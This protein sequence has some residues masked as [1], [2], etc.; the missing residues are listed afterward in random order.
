[1]KFLGLP[2]V[3]QGEVGSANT[4][5]VMARAGLGFMAFDPVPSVAER[6]ARGL[7]GLP[8]VDFARLSRY[9]PA[10]VEAAGL[11]AEAAGAVSRQAVT[12]RKGQTPAQARVA[13][14]V[15]SAGAAGAIE[16]VQEHAATVKDEI[17]T[18]V[19]TLM[20]S[21]PA[22]ARL[23]AAAEVGVLPIYVSR[24]QSSTAFRTQLNQEA[25][26]RF[27]VLMLPFEN[28]QRA[29]RDEHDRWKINRQNQVA[30]GMDPDEM[31]GWDDQ[32]PEP[33]IGQYQGPLIAQASRSLFPNSAQPGKDYMEALREV[34]GLMD[35][36][37]GPERM[38]QL[39]AAA[40][41]IVDGNADYYEAVALIKQQG[42]SGIISDPAFEVLELG[43]LMTEKGGTVP[44]QLEGITVEGQRTP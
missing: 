4:Q 6:T 23:A 44:T 42:I 1:M 12:A 37:V 22:F 33:K 31:E 20:G 25:Q 7:T 21:D 13:E 15:P 34:T 26:R 17:L 16:T 28:A 41:S 39:N 27:E 19:D 30:Q 36:M 24:I 3:P 14:N 2:G 18:E 11:E 32:N 29:W 38:A 5:N 10:H 9:S 43:R 35:S 8:D 40:Q